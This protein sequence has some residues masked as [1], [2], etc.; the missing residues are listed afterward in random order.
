VELDVKYGAALPEE[1]RSDD[2]ENS[3]SEH[4][5]SSYLGKLSILLG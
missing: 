2:V 1:N 3:S 4:E 5:E